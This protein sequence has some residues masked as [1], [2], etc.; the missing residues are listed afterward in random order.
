MDAIDGMELVD[1]MLQGGN[2]N[3]YGLEYDGVLGKIDVQ[4]HTEAL[5]LFIFPLYLC[6]FYV[7]SNRYTLKTFSIIRIPTTSMS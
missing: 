2:D 3:K 1:H 6:H 7:Y 5:L 4:R